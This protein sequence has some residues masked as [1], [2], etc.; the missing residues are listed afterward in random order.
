MTSCRSRH[1][2]RAGNFSSDQNRV[3]CTVIAEPVST[4]ARQ[5]L[6]PMRILRRG[7]VLTGFPGCSEL[8]YSGWLDVELAALT[9]DGS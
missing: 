5:D 6:F 9:L 7:D 1:W 2:L 8:D 3:D 4:T